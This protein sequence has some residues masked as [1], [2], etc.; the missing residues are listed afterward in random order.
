ML[1]I[2]MVLTLQL[3]P[4]MLSGSSNEYNSNEDE[5][6][7]FVCTFHL[8]IQ[9]MFYNNKHGYSISPQYFLS[10][11]TR[12]A[13][14]F[15]ANFSQLMFD[16]V[17]LFLFVLKQFEDNENRDSKYSQVIARKTHNQKSQY[18]QEQLNT[19]KYTLSQRQPK[20]DGNKKN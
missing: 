16:P 8:H 10:L 11:H 1:S 18:L 15:L 2:T 7:S 3:L 20:G 19:G 9:H 14:H 6:N 5:T 12:S 13:R 4:V 17:W